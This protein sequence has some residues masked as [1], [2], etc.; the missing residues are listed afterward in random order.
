MFDDKSIDGGVAPY[1]NGRV[2]PGDRSRPSK[3][4]TNISLFFQQATVE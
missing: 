1:S 3:T 2:E 4:A